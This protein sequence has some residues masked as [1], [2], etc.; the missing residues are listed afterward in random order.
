MD[1]NRQLRLIIAPFFFYAVLFSAKLFKC[2]ISWIED[3]SGD[4]SIELIGVGVT[5]L[6][7]SVLPVGFIFS[8]FG[9][10][11]TRGFDCWSKGRWF[12][13]LNEKESVDYLSKKGISEDS[14]GNMRAKRQG[15]RRQIYRLIRWTA[16]TV[17]HGFSFKCYEGLHRFITRCYTAQSITVNTLVALVVGMVIVIA[18]LPITKWWLILWT[19]SL[20]LLGLNVFFVRADLRRSIRLAYELTKSEKNISSKDVDNT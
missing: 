12:S 14:M 1:P 4:L 15:T 19:S 11:L 20:I 10:L 17:D 18:C 3:F 13:D 16:L 7:L 2:G 9:A 5:L 6:A 8:T